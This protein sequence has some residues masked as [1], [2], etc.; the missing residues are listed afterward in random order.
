MRRPEHARHR[1]RRQDRAARV[2]RAPHPLHVLRHPPGDGERAHAAQRLHR[3]RV[4]AYPRA[5]G[6]HL[7]GAVD[8]GPGLRAHRRR[9]EALAHP[10]RA[11]QRGSGQPAGHDL[12]LVPRMDGQQRGAQA[13]RHQRRHAAARGRPHGPGPANR[14]A[15]RRAAGEGR[16]PAGEQPGAASDPAAAQGRRGTGRPRVQLRGHHLHPRRRHRRHAGP[17]PRLPGDHR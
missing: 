8:R 2:H 7:Q 14:Q 4:G 17:L 5:R 15:H 6:R 13:R 1:L 9:R 10:G 3:G 11:R 16:C 12:P